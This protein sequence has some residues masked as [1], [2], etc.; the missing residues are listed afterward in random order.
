MR[1]AFI[2]LTG[3]GIRKDTREFAFSA[4]QAMRLVLAHMK[5]RRPGVRIEDERGNPVSFFE[6][7]EKAAIEA[8]KEN[9]NRP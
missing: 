1:T 9:A 6:L 7:K 4:T 3:T 5:R 2:V 8:R